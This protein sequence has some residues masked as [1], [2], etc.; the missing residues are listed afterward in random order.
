M[1]IFNG[2]LDVIRRMPVGGTQV[3]QEQ[4]FESRRLAMESGM[5]PSPT[6]LTSIPVLLICCFFVRLF[7]I[8][9]S[10]AGNPL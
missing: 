6:A 9:I 1:T 3:V 5:A 8:P 10:W 2:L 7:D 4:S